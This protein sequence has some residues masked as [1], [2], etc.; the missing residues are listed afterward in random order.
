[1]QHQLDSME[2]CDRQPEIFS[3]TQ[4]KIITSNKE[5]TRT[6]SPFS[7]FQETKENRMELQNRFTVKFSSYWSENLHSLLC[8]LHPPPKKIVNREEQIT[9][10]KLCMRMSFDL[11][12]IYVI[13]ITPLYVVYK[14]ELTYF[15]CMSLVGLPFL[16]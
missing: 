7:L 12:N 2:R 1:M 14:P 5:L 16:E 10:T 15:S 6:S 9:K 4:M 13:K 8:H 3:Q 11:N